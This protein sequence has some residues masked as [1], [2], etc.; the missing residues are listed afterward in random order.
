LGA[1]RRGD[2]LCH[3]EVGNAAWRLSRKRLGRRGL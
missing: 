2:R 3:S 1:L